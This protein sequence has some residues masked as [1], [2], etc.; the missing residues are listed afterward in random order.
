[1]NRLPS[2]QRRALILTAA[3]AFANKH[4]L[5]QLTPETVSDWCAAPTTP[6]TVLKYFSTQ[7]LRHAVAHDDR[8][9]D[10]VRSAARDSGIIRPDPEQPTLG[11]L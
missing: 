10:D 1:M 5:F 7:D 3:V 6:R 4:G 8:A 2:Q 9:S 11:D